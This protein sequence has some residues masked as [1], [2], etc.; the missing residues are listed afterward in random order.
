M[1]VILEGL[2]NEDFD[3][4]DDEVVKLITLPRNKKLKELLN[5]VGVDLKSIK[6]K[7][8]RDSISNRSPL[9]K[10]DVNTAISNGRILAMVFPSG[11]IYIPG[12]KNDGYVDRKDDDGNLGTLTQYMHLSK[13][14]ISNIADAYILS[15]DAKK[16]RDKY[17]DPRYSS[18]DGRYM[19]Q[20]LN[21]NYDPDSKY[22]YY[23]NKWISPSDRSSSRGHSD[24]SGYSVKSI[25]DL[26]AD[27]YKKYKNGDVDE[28]LYDKFKKLANRI[29]EAS[30][31]LKNS[32][33]PI[34]SLLDYD[35][36]FSS[37][38]WEYR[39]LDKY[40]SASRNLNDV[41][42]RYRDLMYEINNSRKYN[43]NGFSVSGYIKSIDKLNSKIDD[44]FKEIDVIKKSI[45]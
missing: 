10:D 6:S 16:K 45:K 41:I 43:I 27:L 31:E 5:N 37:A 12:A 24:K 30:T 44:L 26:K 21:P 34:N 35:K 1:A 36:D 22:S 32:F 7:A 11:Y 4:I 9:W 18:Y 42:S 38:S 20:S 14:Y 28:Q 19:G 39:V 13:S 2:V 33:D 15:F 25:S 3:N 23:R 40:N 29:I 17:I 8:V